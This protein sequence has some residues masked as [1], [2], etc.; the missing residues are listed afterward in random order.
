VAYDAPVLRY[1]VRLTVVVATVAASLL[2]GSAPSWASG[3]GSGPLL[4]PTSLLTTIE[5]EDGKPTLD[6]SLRGSSDRINV[7]PNLRCAL[8][9]EGSHDQFPATDPCL[10]LVDHLAPV[11]DSTP[12]GCISS[13]EPDSGGP[14]PYASW[15]CDMRVFQDLVIRAAQN[16][17]DRSFVMF[18]APSSGGSGVCATI[19]ITVLLGHGY[20][21]LQAADGCPQTIRCEADYA[22]TVRSDSGDTVTGCS[23]GS[24]GTGGAG[25]GGSGGS[26]GGA[27]G[28]GGSGG[29]GGSGSGG[30]G[31]SVP[32]APGS[33]SKKPSGTGS[34][35]G[36]GSACPGA[37]SGKKGN[38]PLYSVYIKPLGKRGMKIYVHMR[39]AVPITV[40][41]RMRTSSGAKVVRWVSRCAKKGNNVITLPNAT[42][43]AKAR[44]NYRVYVKSPN[45]TYP[46]RSSW[47]ALPR[48]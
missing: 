6:W 15:R 35:S 43:G 16:A 10:W 32:A 14:A 45:S 22:G 41:V 46:L 20:G 44:R 3:S 12:P 31:S 24:G 42:G 37:S 7:L 21:E 47:E 8:G 25:S 13:R 9:P 18:N 33:G 4:P 19:P 40:D 27:G 26:G 17:N 36:K 30:G 38:S 29:A 5:S 2:L 11:P 34:T 48:R 28:S 23:G 1:S 39:R